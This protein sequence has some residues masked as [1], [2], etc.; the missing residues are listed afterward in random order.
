MNVRTEDALMATSLRVGAEAGSMY[1]LTQHFTG[2]AD[3]KEKLDAVRASLNLAALVLMDLALEVQ[4]PVEHYTALA[5]QA[6]AGV[7]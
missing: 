5:E 6:K 2:P 3:V 7:A 4:H 1:R